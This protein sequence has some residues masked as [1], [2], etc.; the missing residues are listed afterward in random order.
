MPN[1]SETT[2][3]YYEEN[4]ESFIERTLHLDMEEIPFTV[5]E[6]QGRLG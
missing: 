1:S 4:A 3:A 5:D 6:Q 2:R